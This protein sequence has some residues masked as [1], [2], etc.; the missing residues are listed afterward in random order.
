M[1]EYFLYLCDMTT[2]EKLATRIKR[3]LGIDIVNF[4]RSYA[5]IHMQSSGAPLWRAVVR[6]SNSEYNSDQTATELLKC[7]TL[8]DTRSWS[9]GI[10]AIVGK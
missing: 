3:E 1:W 5:G 10:S 9:P 4:Q 6:G 8:T 7:K 2:F